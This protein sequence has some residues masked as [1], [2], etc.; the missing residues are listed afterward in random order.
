[1]DDDKKPEVELDPFR[2][3]NKLQDEKFERRMK[4]LDHMIHF[5]ET[6]IEQFEADPETPD[7]QLWSFR[8]MRNTLHY[9]KGI[10]NDYKNRSDGQHSRTGDTD[11]ND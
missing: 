10:V 6:K 4:T 8:S 9:V 3:L 5:Y 7:K 11:D 2:P 1:M